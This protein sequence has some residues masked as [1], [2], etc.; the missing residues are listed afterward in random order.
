M[1]QVIVMA[2]AWFRLDEAWAHFTADG[3]CLIGFVILG[4]KAPYPWPLWAG[5]FEMA[6]LALMI[7]RLSGYPATPA[8]Y[9]VLNAICAGGV[10]ASLAIGTFRVKTA[11]RL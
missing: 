1:W 4:W 11:S 8:A 2:A 7:N 5:G 6:A 3:L 9:A 10:L